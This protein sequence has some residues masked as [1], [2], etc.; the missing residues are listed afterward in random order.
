MSS[1]ICLLI[2]DGV[3][4]GRGMLMVEVKFPFAPICVQVFLTSS[5]I[6]L[7]CANNLLFWFKMDILSTL[8]LKVKECLFHSKNGALS[9]LDFM[10]VNRKLW[11]CYYV[12]CY[13]SKSCKMLL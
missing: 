8:F 12:C 5:N 6:S 9:I 2:V 3:T 7:L 4:I 1:A 11:L 10:S 13:L